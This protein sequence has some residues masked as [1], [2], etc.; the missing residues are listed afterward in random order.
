MRSALL[1][2]TLLVMHCVQAQNLVPNWSFEQ[3]EE[4]PV[5]L[6]EV[7]KATGWL[8]FRGSESCD[9][10]H[11]CSSL[12]ATSVPLNDFGEQVPASGNAYAGLYTFSASEP[13]PYVAREYFG[14]E[15]IEPLHVGQQYYATFK[16]SRAPED[17]GPFS[18]GDLRYA[19]NN[20]GLLFSTNYFFQFDLDPAP[21]YAHVRSELVVEDSLN[22][23]MVSGS[24]IADSAY[25]YVVVGNFFNDEETEATL[26]NPDAYWNLAYYF[27]DDVCVSPDPLYCQLVSGVEDTPSAAFSVWQGE[28]GAL[29]FAGMQQSGV[30]VIHVLDALGRGV[31]QYHVNGQDQGSIG[32][33]GWAQGVYVVQAEQQ[34]GGRLAERVFLG[35]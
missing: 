31:A 3:I 33:L 26:V 34:N 19:S 16:V 30:N 15:L 10:F 27:V 18:A 5:Y 20:M 29:Q 11:T 1:I 24:F 22:W 35:R 12:A 9:L 14:I 28:D 21:G 4:C 17:N 23:T 8:I 6:G 25:R 32:T 7:E 2:P 13:F